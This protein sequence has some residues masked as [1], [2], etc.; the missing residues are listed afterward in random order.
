MPYVSLSTGARIYHERV[1]IGPPLILIMGTGLDHSCWDAQVQ[2]Y[3]DYFEC[4][5]FDDRGTG[6]SSMPDG[7]LSIRLLAEDTSAP[8][9]ALGIDRAHV[10]GLSLGSCVAQE[11]ALMRPDLVETLQ[12]HGTWARAHGYAARKFRAQLRLLHELDVETFYDINVLWF[13]T[14]AYMNDHPERVTRQI[15]SIVRSAP[16]R[17][18]LTSMYQANLD[19]DTLGR[20]PAIQAPTLVTVGS[21]DAALPPMYG[22]EVATAIPNSEIVVF[23]GGG[24]LHNIERPEEFNAVTLEFLRRHAPAPDMIDYHRVGASSESDVK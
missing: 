4:V 19:H 1:G 24:H 3:R 22:Q 20:L 2:A 12:L 16:P 7:D 14:P 15:D 9:E 6:R 5:V 10:S 13:L 21:L 18:F 11:L 17:E 8:A 23:E